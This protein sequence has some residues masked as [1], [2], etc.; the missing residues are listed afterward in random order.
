MNVVRAPGAKP[1]HSLP[2]MGDHHTA[3]SMH[4]SMVTALL[5][6]ER[7]GESSTVH[8]S[9]IANGVR[10]ASCIAAAKFA[11]AS[12]FSNHPNRATRYFTREM[13]ETADRRWLQ[14]AFVGSESEVRRFLEVPGVAE[15]LYDP[16][17]STL[18]ARLRSGTALADR[19]RPVLGSRTTADW[20]AIFGADGVPVSLVGSVRT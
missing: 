3:I 10:A 5:H 6:G 17:F 11:H 8:M 15:L 12:D 20:L 9:L 16:G 14:F 19:L 18:D 7:T 4:A 1:P 13:S 2:G